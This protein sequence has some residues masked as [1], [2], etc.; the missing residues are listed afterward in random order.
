M[1]SS[2]AQALLR[3]ATFTLIV[4]AAA[5]T[6]PYVRSRLARSF[7]QVTNTAVHTERIHRDA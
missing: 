7:V 1:A 6:V 3:A 5:I 2:R 4:C